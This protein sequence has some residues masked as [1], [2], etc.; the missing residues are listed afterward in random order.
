MKKEGR[1][2]ILL[3]L[4]LLK[5][6][7]ESE[8]FDYILIEAVFASVI[9]GYAIAIVYFLQGHVTKAIGYLVAA[10]INLAVYEYIRKKR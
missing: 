6:I 3:A 5:R 1:A 4:R 2:E 9:V 10:S 8:K 7:V